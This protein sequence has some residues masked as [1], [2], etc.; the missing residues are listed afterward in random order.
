MFRKKKKD[1]PML[2]IEHIKNDEYIALDTP[3]CP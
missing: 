2:T 1:T 3:T